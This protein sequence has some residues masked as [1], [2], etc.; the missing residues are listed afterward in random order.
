MLVG[1]AVSYGT[2]QPRTTTTETD[3]MRIR[4][5]VRDVEGT[6]IVESKTPFGIFSRFRE[7][8]GK[9]QVKNYGSPIPVFHDAIH[10]KKESFDFN[11]E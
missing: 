3:K 2:Q 6:S 4:H 10:I 9:G 5:R 7:I 8:G 1:I 11:T